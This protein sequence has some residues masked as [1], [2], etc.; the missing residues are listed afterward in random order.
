MVSKSIY[1]ICIL[2]VL[3]VTFFSAV[4]QTLRP[5]VN[6]A[7]YWEYKG[8]PVLLIGGSDTHNLFQMPN[9]KDHLDLLQ[10]VGGNY[11]RN[12]MSSREDGNLHPF[13][14]LADGKYDLDQWNSEFWKRFENLLEWTSEKNI[15]VQVEIWDKWDFAQNRWPFNPWN[16]ENNINY[17]F[18]DTKLKALYDGFF[19]EV[20]DFFNSVPALNHDKKV[21]YFQKKFVDK[22]LSYTLN[23]DHVLYT[24]DNELHPAFSV[25]WP[26]YWARYIHRVALNNGTP[27]QVTE[28]FWTPEL[29]ARDHKVVIDNPELFTYFEAS[30]NTSNTT[31]WQ[32]W[33]NFHWLRYLLNDSR[34][35]VN[36]VKIY[37]KENGPNYL[38][39]QIFAGAASSRFHRPDYGI[40]LN[41]EA[42]T[43]IRSMRMWLQE[44]DIFSGQPDG[45]TSYVAGHQHLENREWDEAFCIYREGEQYSVYFRNG[46]EVSL[47]VP[48]GMWELRWL[49]ISESKWKDKPTQHSGDRVLLKTPGS[50]YWLA[51]ISRIEY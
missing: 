41:V 33:R 37:S 40:G 27:V 49:N 50:G 22:I 24:I 36:I 44:Y 15:F 31:P 47:K 14:Q 12:T 25:E 45:N 42:Q 23:Y 26:L 10:S 8:N 35:P 38:W 39:Q 2:L 34:R 29:R 46:G 48:E 1:V 18:E 19:I 3:Q 32:H 17:S 43:H 6:N 16:P 5:Y 4:S 11:I 20:H 28:M 13:L 21:L 7:W 51:L 9:L 30:Q